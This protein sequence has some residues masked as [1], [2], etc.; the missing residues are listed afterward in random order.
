MVIRLWGTQR[1]QSFLTANC[2]CKME[3][4]H[5]LIDPKAKVNHILILKISDIQKSLMK[6]H[7]QIQK[8]NVPCFV[9]E[10]NHNEYCSKRERLIVIAQFFSRL[11]YFKTWQCLNIIGFSQLD[12]SPN[13][14]Q[15]ALSQ[16]V[17]VAQ[18]LN[19]NYKIP[20][21][22]RLPHVFLILKPNV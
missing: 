9:V 10:S 2:A 5:S 18:Q 16:N 17:F 20:E 11:D 14:L 8:L 6:L 21:I 13:F 12:K 1:E 7:P 22:F 3:W 4:N 15:I 19:P